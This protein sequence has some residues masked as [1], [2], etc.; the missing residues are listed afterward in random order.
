MIHKCY[1][2]SSYKINDMITS[3]WENTHTNG[4]IHVHGICYLGMGC[5]DRSTRFPSLP[6]SECVCVC[7]SASLCFTSDPGAGITCA[8]MNMHGC[9]TLVL[10]KSTYFTRQRDLL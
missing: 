4:I 2:S 9:Y 3:I 7:L 8:Q 6:L 5:P 1:V 10:F